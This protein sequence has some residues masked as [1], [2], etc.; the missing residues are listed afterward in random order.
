MGL[1]EA[2]CGFLVPGSGQI[3]HKQYLHGI[4]VLLVAFGSAL[5]LIFLMNMQW[6]A[7]MSSYFIVGL[8]SALDAYLF[9]HR[10]QEVE[11]KQLQEFSEFEKQKE[12]RREAEK[13]KAKQKLMQFLADHYPNLVFTVIDF[14]RKENYWRAFIKAEDKFYELKLDDLGNIIGGRP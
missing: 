6:Y 2:V 10:G 1:L 3:I 4:V 8:Y 5:S 9:S 13:E 7:A 14:E 12:A 11:S